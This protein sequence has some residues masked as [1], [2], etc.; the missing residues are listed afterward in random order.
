MRREDSPLVQTEALH[1]QMRKVQRRDAADE[2]GR[3]PTMLKHS[4]SERELDNSPLPRTAP[5][6]LFPGVSVGSSV[7]SPALDRPPALGRR[8]VQAAPPSDPWSL[9]ERSRDTMEGVD[10]SSLAAQLRR[11]RGEL[12]VRVEGSMEAARSTSAPPAAPLPPAVTVTDDS[13][14]AAPG[15]SKLRPPP[16]CLAR[17]ARQAARLSSTSP[18]GSPRAAW[19]AS[20]P[21]PL[22]LPGD[23]EAASGG[24][25]NEHSLASLG[26]V[27]T[28]LSGDGSACPTTPPAKGRAAARLSNTPLTSPRLMSPLG[29]PPPPRCV[30]SSPR[31]PTDSM[32]DTPET[33]REGRSFPRRLPGAQSPS[34]P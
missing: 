2:A 31:L 22:Q 13:V 18:F 20:A 16:S 17:R 21:S 14:R 28:D 24:G 19:Q 23:A 32:P 5:S 34:L 29:S 10:G 26:L 7:C 33:P 30:A 1:P 15:E 27:V 12:D 4:L 25:G 8:P 3:S 9:S 11:L 6:G